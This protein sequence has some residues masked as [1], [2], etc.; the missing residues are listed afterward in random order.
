MSI[1]LEKIR[2]LY[3]IGVGGIGMSALARYFN[4]AGAKVSGYDRYSSTLTDELIREGIQIHFEENVNLIPKKID[5]VVYTPAIPAEHAELIYYKENNYTVVKRADLLEA[6][7]TKNFTI[8]IAGT[9][10]KTTTTTMIAHILKSSDYDCTAFLGGISVN[11][12]SNFIPGK[13]NVIVV[14]ADEFDRSFLKLNPEI[15]VITSCDADHLDVYHSEIEVQKAFDAFALKVKRDG[16]L[17]IK[18]NLPIAKS[19]SAKKYSYQTESATA[20]FHCKNFS[21]KN[22]MYV[23]DLHSLFE[24]ILGIE[25]NVPGKHNVENTVAAIAVAQVLHIN[26]EKIKNAVKTFSGVKRRFEFIVKNE[27][28]IFIDDYAHHPNEISAFLKSVKEIFPDKK[29]TCIFQPHLYS[30]TSDFANEFSKSLSLVDELILLPI[31]PA[32]ELP[33]EGINSEMLLKNISAKNKCVANKEESLQL[34]EKEKPELLVTMGAGD[35]DQLVPKI[36]LILE[37]ENFKR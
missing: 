1:D 24:N 20:D 15:A 5:L 17:I 30:R 36:K 25:M 29:L 13:N 22:G 12:D 35:I 14:E 2:S 37:N 32:R 10:G 31:Y 19:I 11:Y 16:A 23:F 3:F 27:K 6:V 21:L 8:A 9:H 7:T 18:E 34:I 33:I 28:Q 26:A 4:F